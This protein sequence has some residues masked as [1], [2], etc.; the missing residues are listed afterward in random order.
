MFMVYYIDDYNKKHLTFVKE[1]S[2][3][4]FLKYRFEIISIEFIKKD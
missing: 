1:I 3:L 4:N 2:E